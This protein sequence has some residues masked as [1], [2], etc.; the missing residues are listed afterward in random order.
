MD[1]NKYVQIRM[2]IYIHMF[3]HGYINVHKYTYVHVHDGCTH[4]KEIPVERCIYMKQ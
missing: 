3:M 2:C 4:H 1:T